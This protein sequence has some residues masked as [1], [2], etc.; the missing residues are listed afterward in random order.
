M[1]TRFGKILGKLLV[2]Q[3][4]NDVIGELTTNRERDTKQM[5]EIFN[6]KT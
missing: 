3:F 5:Y 6:T 1:N 2:D 4:A